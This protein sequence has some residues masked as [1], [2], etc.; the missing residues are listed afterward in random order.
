MAM[1]TRARLQGIVQ[2]WVQIYGLGRVENLAHPHSPSFITDIK[3]PRRTILLQRELQMACSVKVLKNNSATTAQCNSGK[4]AQCH[5][6]HCQRC[7][8]VEF[9][10]LE[11]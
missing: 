9:G 3:M 2:V 8:A 7:Q 6:I 10:I 5:R 11:R 1:G 4:A